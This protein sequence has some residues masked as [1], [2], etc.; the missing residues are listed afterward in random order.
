MTNLD[1]SI[2]EPQLTFEQQQEIDR[3]AK[4]AYT[5]SS[6]SNKYRFN[7]YA[8]I[9]RLVLEARKEE[10]SDFEPLQRD[11][12]KCLEPISCISYQN[13][14]SDSQQPKQIGE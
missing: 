8:Y 7:L 1:T 14:A 2:D 12:S 13:A 6:N 9:E 10:L 5:P 11:H 3:L 4:L